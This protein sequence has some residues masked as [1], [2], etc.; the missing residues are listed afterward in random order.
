MV[1]RG[2]PLGARRS[3]L[4]A[5][6]PLLN[7]RRLRRQLRDSGHLR[8]HDGLAA[9]SQVDRL[10]A[11]GRRPPLADVFEQSAV[12]APKIRIAEVHDHVRLRPRIIVS[13]HLLEPLDRGDQVVRVR[14]VHFADSFEGAGS[15]VFQLLLKAHEKLHALFALVERHLRGDAGHDG[16]MEIGAQRPLKNHA[17]R[18]DQQHVAALAQ[19]GD[20]NALADFDLDPVGQN[21]ANRRA[22]DPSDGFELAAAL[23]DR[24]R[25]KALS[26]VGG[27][28]F[29]DRRAR[30][31][32]I[33]VNLDLLGMNQLDFGRG[34]EEASALVGNPDA[35]DTGAEPQGGAQV[36]LRSYAAELAALDFERF[37]AAEILRLL[38]REDFL[39][40]SVD[41]DGP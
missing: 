19:E 2:S 33:A 15:R 11:A 4:R 17:V 38:I 16:K 29:E 8:I 26:A 6:H 30:N 13:R 32:V 3:L 10:D 22:L 27:E 18:I 37:L 21:A 5:P 35:C 12:L 25:Q 39:R 9:E 1:S 20:R 36:G 23:I 34:L 31:E 14:K 28:N 40:K 7:D 24:N 41:V